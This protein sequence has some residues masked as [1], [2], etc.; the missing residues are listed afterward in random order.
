MVHHADYWRFRP[1]RDLYQVELCST[2]RGQRVLD[3]YNSD[4]LTL[5]VDETHNGG[6]NALVDTVI[7]CFY[8]LFSPFLT[9]Y[10]TPARQ[11]SPAGI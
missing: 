5:F 6:A 11:F 8:L 7:W 9:R 4:V 10:L 3:W 1:W 2:G